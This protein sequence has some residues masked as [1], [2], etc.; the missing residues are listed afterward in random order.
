MS[1]KPDSKWIVKYNFKS[2]SQ[3]SGWFSIPAG[4]HQTSAEWHSGPK[5]NHLWHLDMFL[6]ELK[7]KKK[8]K[9]DELEN[10]WNNLRA[11]KRF[12][13]TD[14]VIR[15]FISVQYWAFYSKNRHNLCS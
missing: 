5:I 6:T 7:K 12:P 9:L 11:P 10:L 8:A 14:Y 13:D 2:G 1:Y 4:L 15:L 3:H